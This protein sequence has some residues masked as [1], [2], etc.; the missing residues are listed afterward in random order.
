MMLRTFATASAGSV[1]H[2]QHVDAE[3][4]ETRDGETQHHVIVDAQHVGPQAFIHDCRFG[5]RQRPAVLRRAAF[6]SKSDIVE[7]SCV[8][9]FAETQAIPASRRA[10]YGQ[11]GRPNKVPYRRRGLRVPVRSRGGLSRRMSGVQGNP[12]LTGDAGPARASG[13]SAENV[14]IRPNAMVN[15]V[16]P[17]V[18][19]NA[20]HGQPDERQVHHLGHH[21]HGGER[22]RPR[23]R[24]SR[25]RTRPADIPAH[26]R[27][28]ADRAS[29]RASSAP[30]R[31][32]RDGGGRWRARPPAPARRRS[33]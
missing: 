31:H 26:R 9:P 28:A 19:P 15:A 13:P 17:S 2:R 27:R 21:Q 18:A 25:S 24:R 4:G 14:P 23:R 5:P 29:R 11:N 10:Q 8:R 12:R 33:A 3:R 1:G 7:T 30:P 22:S 32:R 16:A 6:R 20:G